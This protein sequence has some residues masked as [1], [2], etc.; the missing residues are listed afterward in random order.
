M[1]EMTEGIRK[2]VV[3]VLLSV[4][5]SVTAGDGALIDLSAVDGNGDPVMGP[6]VGS[7]VAAATKPA[8]G[9]DK[10][11]DSMLLDRPEVPV[12]VA[13]GA[14]PIVAVKKKPIQ[15]VP[16]VHRLCRFEKIKASGWYRVRFVA[17]P[18]RLAL[19]PQVVLPNSLLDAFESLSATDRARA[20]RISGE[21]FLYRRNAFVL[22]RKV[23]FDASAEIQPP[24]LSDARGDANAPSAPTKP[25]EAPADTTDPTKQIIKALMS[26][27]AGKAVVGVEP[28]TKS[29]GKDRSVAPTPSRRPVGAEGLIVAD[30]LVRVLL[31][32]NTGWTVAAFEGDNTLREAP[33]RLLPCAFLERAEGAAGALPLTGIKFRVSGEITAYKGR[34]YLLLR[35]LLPE[36]DMGQ[37]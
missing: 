36:R 34:R 14:K 23:T 8:K 16:I 6:P 15:T 19:P 3:L 11:L 33:V 20:F 9:D 17:E 30:R 26:K 29:A 32:R 18:N 35:K 28:S 4:A 27:R 12:T 13:A 21:T 24:K 5:G 7:L 10:D 37:L 31:A 1:S 2:L 22:L 25:A